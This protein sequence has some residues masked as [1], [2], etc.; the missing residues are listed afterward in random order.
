MATLLAAYTVPYKNFAYDITIHETEHKFYFNQTAIDKSDLEA[1]YP[2]VKHAYSYVGKELPL[3]RLLSFL[4]DAYN[5]WK[6]NNG[7]DKIDN[8]LLNIAGTIAGQFNITSYTYNEEFQLALRLIKP[9]DLEAQK[10]TIFSP[11]PDLCRVKATFK[12]Q[13][14]VEIEVKTFT[15][16][17]YSYD[18]GIKLGLLN[19]K[20]DKNLSGY[21]LPANVI[22]RK[23]EAFNSK[24]V[25]AS[26]VV[27]GWTY[28]DTKDACVG[29]CKDAIKE[30]LIARVDEAKEQLLNFMYPSA[31]EKSAE[32]DSTLSL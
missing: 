30:L 19:G 10:G 32:E 18:S 20:V 4:S 14:D 2:E 11:A 31:P 9:L 6:H 12:G 27:D 15:D 21:E 24:D 3:Q 26:I 16:N 25:P 23:L 29:R 7:G 13:G 22:N 5:I 28:F 8:R 17:I 1:K